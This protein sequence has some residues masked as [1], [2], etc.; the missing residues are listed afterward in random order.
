MVTFKYLFLFE[1]DMPLR[2]I[3]RQNVNLS[4]KEIKAFIKTV[5]SGKLLD[6]EKIEEFEDL[7]RKYTGVKHA[8]SVGSGRIALYLL[9]KALDVKEGDEII[10]PAYN[11][12]IVPDMVLCI[13]AKPVFVDV[14][15]D[16]YNID[17]SKIEEKISDKTKGII[18]THMHGQPCNMATILKI[19]KKKKLFLIEDC[20]HVCGAEYNGR[21]CGSFGTA[22][23]FSFGMSKVIT[24]FEGGMITTNNSELFEKIKKEIFNYK[25]PSKIELMRKIFSTFYALFFTSPLMFTFISFPLICFCDKIGS[26]FLNDLYEEKEK[27]I[28][29]IPDKYKIKFTNVQAAVG[30]EQLKRIDELNNKRI[31]NAKLLDKLLTRM[32]LKIPTAMKNTKCIYLNYLVQSDEREKIIKHLLSK[33]IDTRKDYISDCSSLGIFKEF[34]SYCPVANELV[35]KGFFLP[36]HT[37][38]NKKDIFR[39]VKSL[40]I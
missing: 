35:K 11:Y 25:Y 6:G 39:I 7:F 26:N 37:S 14:D 36:I 22:S 9:L 23:Y 34:N 28:K 5:F 15:K 33:G 17:V 3:P 30:I 10:L 2:A 12:F 24:S 8:I 20:A 18:L 21:R 38:V 31:E 40:K 1:Q 32:D 27:L 29:S 16:T 4:G 13:G 19:V